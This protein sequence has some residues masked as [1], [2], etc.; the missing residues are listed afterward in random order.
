MIQNILIGVTAFGVAT[1]WVLFVE[2]GAGESRPG[3]TEIWI[4]FPKFVFGFV[5]ASILFSLLYEQAD[6]GPEIVTAIIK[7][8]TKTLRGWF[9]C[10]AFVCIGL[11]MN[12]RK[13]AQSMEG[14][15]PLVLYLVGQSLNLILTLAMAWWMFEVVYKEQ[16]DQFLG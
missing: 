8:S 6:R 9:F 7:G 13:L 4:R 14:G 3:W 11:E 1:Y 5:A 15:K 12:F 16:L 2:S 10:L